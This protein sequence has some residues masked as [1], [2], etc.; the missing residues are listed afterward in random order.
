MIGS[1]R[2]L[3]LP[4]RS[5]LPGRRSISCVGSKVT[6]FCGVVCLPTCLTGWINSF[7]LSFRSVTVFIVVGVVPEVGIRVRGGGGTVSVSRF[8]LII[9]SLFSLFFQQSALI[10]IMTWFFT[11]VARWFGSVDISVCG[12]LAHSV[13]L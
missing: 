11:V 5:S 12:L 9:F 13:Y 8:I 1:F 2:R 3:V 7:W 6:F 4:F 10:S